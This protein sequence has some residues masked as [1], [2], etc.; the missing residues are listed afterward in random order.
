MGFR[1]TTT[2]PYFTNIPRDVVNNTLHYTWGGG[3]PP[4][5]AEIEVLA[6]A[7]AGF[8]ESLYDNGSGNTSSMANYMRPNLAVTRVYDASRP[9]PNPPVYEDVTPL[10]VGTQSAT[11]LPTEVAMVLSFQGALLAGTPQ[12]RRRG[13]IY[14]GG[15]ANTDDPSGTSA[16]PKPSPLK[17]QN[18]CNAASAYLVTLSGTSWTWCVFSR[19]NNNYVPVT[20]GWVDDAYDTQRRRGQDPQA[21]TLWT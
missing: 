20:N 11:S 2:I 12:A 19:V 14:L 13:R 17:V 7:H 15:L 1:V 16:F 21:R 3:S 10:V 9:T 5:D 4:D 18:R 8:I 6:Q